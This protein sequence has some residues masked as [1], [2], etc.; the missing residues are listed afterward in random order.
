MSD[1]S[2]CVTSCGIANTENLEVRLGLEQE[3][4]VWVVPF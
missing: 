2:H 3:R 4:D 1:I